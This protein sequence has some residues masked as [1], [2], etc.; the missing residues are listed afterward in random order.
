[1][2]LVGASVSCQLCTDVD[3]SSVCWFKVSTQIAGDVTRSKHVELFKE[4]LWVKQSRYSTRLKHDKT[5]QK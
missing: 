4:T 1:M 2:A 3:Q 5:K